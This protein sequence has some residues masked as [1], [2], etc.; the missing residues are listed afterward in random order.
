[1][2]TNDIATTPGALQALQLAYL[3]KAADRYSPEEN[4]L[5]RQ[6]RNAAL[7]EYEATMRQ[8]PKV[9]QL[10]MGLN[11]WMASP[12]GGTKAGIGLAVG[13]AAK[14]YQEQEQGMWADKMKALQNLATMRENAIR[15]DDA[16]LR[17]SFGRLGAA[18]QPVDK[19]TPQQQ[20]A[21]RTAIN[22]T[23]ADLAKN[24][25]GMDP[26]ERKREAIRMVAESTGYSI[27]D[28][29]QFVYGA[30]AVK[31]EDTTQQ[32]QPNSQTPYSV[33]SQVPTTPVAQGED[34]PK[35]SGT[36]QAGRDQEAIAI[37]FDEWNRLN[38]DAN[39]Y[40]TGDSRKLTA[41]N[42]AAS[43]R[44]ELMK[45]FNIDPLKGMPTLSVAPQQS[46]VQPTQTQPAAPQQATQPAARPLISTQSKSAAY[47]ESPFAAG[48]NLPEVVG[49]SSLKVDREVHEKQLNEF[50]KGDAYKQIQTQSVG[51]KELIDLTNQ[52]LKNDLKTDAL[53]GVKTTANRFAQAFGVPVSKEAMAEATKMAELGQFS[54]A[55]GLAE[56]LAQ[57]GNQTDAD[58][59]RIVASVFDTTM[60]PRTRKSLLLNY[61]D[62]IN[63][64]ITRGK[65]ADEFLGHPNVLGNVM[66]FNRTY[67]DYINGPSGKLPESVAVRKGGKIEVLPL[68]EAIRTFHN[69]KAGGQFKFSKNDT[70]EEQ[71][72]KQAATIEALNKMNAAARAALL[73]D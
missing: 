12:Y 68:D 6:R 46:P 69:T 31:Q 37:A 35:V 61:G 27:P 23:E 48:L 45:R 53:S 73:K 15:N 70:P 1:M 58:F 65:F 57:K 24:L 16:T 41:L 3:Q 20:V 4:E 56:Q 7:D 62:K 9:D 39:R 13:Q 50:Q 51:G 49:P 43:V 33:V 29:L 25:P 30:K 34:Y 63:A 66:Q 52:A 67:T 8:A 21:L 5:M 17:G 55:L 28:M 60:E 72:Q 54:N 64:R 14:Q 19:I 26:A 59:L 11:N 32:A 18:R 2:D 40:P 22:A 47:K 10:T 38:E 44:K 42:G 71:A 36:L